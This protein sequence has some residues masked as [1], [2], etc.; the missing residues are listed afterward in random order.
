YSLDLKDT[1]G[2]SVTDSRNFTT[3]RYALLTAADKVTADTSKPGFIW[4]V[5]QNNLLTTDST[6]RPL[7]QLAGLLGQNFA[8]PNAQGVALA[9]G[10]PG[11]NNQLQITFEIPA[12]L[13][14]NIDSSGLGYGKFTTHVYMPVS[15]DHNPIV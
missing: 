10:T 14:L 15:R 6:D 11:A 2:N 8:D 5:H 13:K 9:A 1:Q 7:N 4:K 12:V 3:P